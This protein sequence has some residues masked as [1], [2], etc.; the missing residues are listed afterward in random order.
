M[1]EGNNK[2]ENEWNRKQWY[3]RKEQQNPKFVLSKSR[4]IEK[5]LVKFI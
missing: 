2:A 1:E 4:K 5:T 3:S